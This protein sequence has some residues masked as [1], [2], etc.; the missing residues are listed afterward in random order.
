MCVW[1]DSVTETILVCVSVCLL[2]FV[3]ASVEEIGFAVAVRV[4]RF[5][6][7]CLIDCVNV[8]LSV[9]FGMCVFSLDCCV[10]FT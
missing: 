10:V 6:C 8:S 1:C 3:L 2:I 7:F 5:L 9:S 4:C